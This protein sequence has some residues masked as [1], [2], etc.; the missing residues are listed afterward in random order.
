MTQLV[1]G[2][3]LT[4]LAA[5]FV[6]HHMCNVLPYCGGNY[7]GVHKYIVYYEELSH[8]SELAEENVEVP[9]PFLCPITL[10]VMKDPVVAMDGHTYE[11]SSITKWFANH[12]TS[13]KTNE[14]LTRKKLVPNHALRA[15]IIE[16]H[17]QHP[18]KMKCVAKRAH[19]RKSDIPTSSE[20]IYLDVEPTDTLAELKVRFLLLRASYL[21]SQ[22]QR[23][24][25]GLLISTDLLNRQR[26][27]DAG[28]RRKG[29]RGSL[30]K[31][32]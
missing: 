24:N 32:C 22:R 30:L 19:L 11:R 8:S 20:I 10:D 18:C 14:E 12:G 15:M 13:P 28:A 6:L 26:V 25:S 29:L 21:L 1:L 31:P 4:Q 5:T 17:E 3:I 23:W 7:G 9:N 27:R 16:W 2:L